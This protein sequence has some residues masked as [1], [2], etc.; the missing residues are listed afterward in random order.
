MN[1]EFFNLQAIFLVFARV[2]PAL[3]QETA[4]HNNAF[5]NAAKMSPPLGQQVAKVNVIEQVGSYPLGVGLSC[6]AQQLSPL[7]SMRFST[8]KS[9]ELPIRMEKAIDLPTGVRPVTNDP[10]SD[11]V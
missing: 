11:L 3:K 1:L 7:P 2:T 9:Q 5:S 8:P 10:T 6:P 4:V